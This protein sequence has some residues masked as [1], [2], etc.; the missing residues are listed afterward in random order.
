MKALIAQIASQSVQAGGKGGLT[1]LF[2]VLAGRPKNQ[3][4]SPRYVAA[5]RQD[6]TIGRCSHLDRRQL[7]HSVRSA[8][9]RTVGLRPLVGT[10]ET[11][12]TEP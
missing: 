3:R 4:S 1:P 11:A 2:T 7:H 10:E 12:V 8:G 5:A 9:A 6:S